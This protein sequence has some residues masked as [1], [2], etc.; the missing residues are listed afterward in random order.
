MCWIM[1]CTILTSGCKGEL[2]RWELK[3]VDCKKP[4]MIH[5]DHTGNLFSIVTA[6]KKFESCGEADVHEENWMR[7]GETVSAWTFGQERNLLKTTIDAQSNTLCCYPTVG[8]SVQ[9]IVVSPIDP[10][11]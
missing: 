1:P 7:E 4:K 3:D 9:T 2:L 11:K 6:F 5:N 10:H 8:S